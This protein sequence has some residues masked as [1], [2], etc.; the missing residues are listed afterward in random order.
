MRSV[1]L[2][3]LTCLAAVI[4]AVAQTHSLRVPDMPL[5][6]AINLLAEQTDAVIIAEAADLAGLRA[7]PLS[8]DMQV[9]EA[10]SA[11]LSGSSLSVSQDGNGVWIIR[12]QQPDGTV[13][14]RPAPDTAAIRPVRLP[15]PVADL[16]RT[17]C[18]STC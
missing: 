12:R 7:G 5:A 16:P 1:C 2:L 3:L 10:L 4:P 11:L 6:D 8:G 9:D 18:C 15:S 17:S 13:P 14:A